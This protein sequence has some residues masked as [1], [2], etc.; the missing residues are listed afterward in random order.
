M[1]LQ[2]RS[3]IRKG[4]V[5]VL[6]LVAVLIAGLLSF[7]CSKSKPVAQAPDGNAAAQSPV[8]RY[9][10]KGKVV[11]VDSNA[12]EANIDAEAIPGFMDA[13]IM[14]YKIKDQGQ[15]QKLSVGDSV[16]AD[17]VVQGH[18]YWLENV[19]VTTHSSTTPPKPSAAMHIPASGEP[20]PDFELVN[21][22]G[23]HISFK[24]FR[25]KVLLLTFIYTRCPFVDYCPRVSHE[26]AEANRQLAATPELLRTT[27]L[28]S[29]SFDPVHDTPSVLRGYGL[30]CAGTR[31]PAVFKHWEFA[32]APA[33]QLPQIADFFG[34]TY[35]EEGGLI[36]HSLSTAVIAPDGSVFKWYN[37]NDWRASDLVK[38]AADA[39]RARS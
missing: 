8:Q 28:L 29:I 35:K 4:C 19:K 20:V 38:D 22:S 24:E 25:G 3:A 31:G 27:H 11:S 12:G 14:P 37:G 15:L 32:A 16:T 13:M 34:F 23:K 5:Q 6:L 9:A 21:Q 30:A 7:S 36:T 10:L 18:E 17:V 39:L 33:A 26:F 2:R 1:R